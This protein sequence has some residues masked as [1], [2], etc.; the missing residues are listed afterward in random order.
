MAE[1]EAEDAQADRGADGT[2]GRVPAAVPAEDKAAA[3]GADK[4]GGSTMMANRRAALP[5]LLLL[6]AAFSLLSSCIVPP[7]PPSDEGG[8]PVAL[9]EW[10]EFEHWYG[11]GCFAAAWVR[12]DEDRV[13]Q[14]EGVYLTRDVDPQVSDEHSGLWQRLDDDGVLHEWTWRLHEGGVMVWPGYQGDSV[15]VAW[16]TGVANDK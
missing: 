9:D 15:A 5:I 2:P 10:I 3:V 13:G 12:L 11:E 6:Y 16:W 14:V 7:Q 4:D 1:A 8:L